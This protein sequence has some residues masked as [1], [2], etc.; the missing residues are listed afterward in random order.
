MDIA[1]LLCSSCHTVEKQSTVIFL[2]DCS[3]SVVTFVLKGKLRTDSIVEAFILSSSFLLPFIACYP[4]KSF[5][6][7]KDSQNRIEDI[8]TLG[9]SQL[10]YSI[11]FPIFSSMPYSGRNCWGVAFTLENREM[12][13]YVKEEAVPHE[14]TN[15]ILL[16]KQINQGSVEKIKRSGTN[17]W[18]SLHK[19]HM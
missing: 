17:S 3:C 5:Q 8:K 10:L 11:M 12:E 1:T 16:K 19:E 14:V 6:S 13:S 9:K 18:G 7:F 15:K 4:T 2:D